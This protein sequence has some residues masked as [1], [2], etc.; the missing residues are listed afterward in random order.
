[1]A[2]LVPTNKV[3]A[4][5]IAGAVV[6]VALGALDASGVH[7]DPTLAAA[8]VTVL[9]FVAAYLKVEKNPVVVA[10]EDAFHPQ[11]TPPVAPAV[12]PANPTGV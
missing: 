7:L 12:P 10:V 11:D 2:S 8:V 4:G 1:M 3:T 5:G 6:T 9:G